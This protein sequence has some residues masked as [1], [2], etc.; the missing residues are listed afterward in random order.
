MVKLLVIDDEA[1]LGELIAELAED[2]G[3]EVRT[4]ADS[5]EVGDVIAAFTPD[6]IMLDLVMPGVD[7]VELLKTFVDSVKNAKIVLMSGTDSRVLN[8]TR[9]LGE[10]HGLNI[11]KTLEKPLEISAIRQAL[12]ELAV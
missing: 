11:I 1:D 3:F 12:D 8:S 10:A 2:R 5:A 7:G 9:R 6:A 4:V